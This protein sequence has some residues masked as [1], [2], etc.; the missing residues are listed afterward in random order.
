MV[1]IQS[2]ADDQIIC[3]GSLLSDQFVL[4]AAECIDDQTAWSIYISVYVKNIRDDVY[5]V[6]QI[7]K[8]SEKKGN[9][10]IALLRTNDKVIIDEYTQPIEIR[11]FSLTRLPKTFTAVSYIKGKVCSTFQVLV[12]Q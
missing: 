3:S 7:I 1:A 5:A 11:T 12:K 4:T 2:M 9:N 8:H 6:E 10:D